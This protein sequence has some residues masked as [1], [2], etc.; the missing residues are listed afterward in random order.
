MPGSQT[1]QGRTGTRIFV[2]VRVAFRYCDSVS[3]LDSRS[4]AAP[5]PGLHAPLSTL[6]VVPHDTPRMTRG[7][8]GLLFLYCVGLSPFTP[9]RSP[10]APQVSSLSN[11][12]GF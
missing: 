9:C 4:F 7:Q 6:H 3:T 5:W 11:F 1:T 2:P 8:Y 10:G 12:L